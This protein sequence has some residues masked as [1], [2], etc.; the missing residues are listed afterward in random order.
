VLKS[1]VLLDRDGTLNVDAGYVYSP[2]RLELIPR[3]A[4]AVSLFVELDL[5]V[6]VV[7]N[8]S[9]VGRG[10]CSLDDVH[11]TNQRLDE[12]LLQAA[13]GAVVEDYFI[14]PHAPED[15][16]DCRKPKTGLLPGRFLAHAQRGFIV[17]DKLSDIELGAR[18]GIDAKRRF[19]V[20]TGHGAQELARAK[21][22]IESVADY[23]RVVPSVL[24]AAEQV[25]REV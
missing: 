9:A 22:E 19:L 21:K 15:N 24:G 18:I 10:M 6:V 20:Q 11:K 8:Q 12:L 5:E 17:G 25:R 13:P 2:E 1:Y 3:A 14:C 4:E 16:C 23:C 7:T